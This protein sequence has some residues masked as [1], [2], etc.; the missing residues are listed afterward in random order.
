M[1]WQNTDRVAAASAL[2]RSTWLQLCEH[3]PTVK[4]VVI[5]GTSHTSRVTALASSA[6]RLSVMA[7]A[8]VT[9]EQATSLFQ[10]T[11]PPRV[12]INPGFFRSEFCLVIGRAAVGNFRNP[13][14]VAFLLCW[15]GRSSGGRNWILLY[16]T[17]NKSKSERHST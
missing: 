10:P 14:G 13:A 3:L 11:T 16:C 7:L 1:D 8:S 15:V 2:K 12:S 6:T 4:V 17:E 5:T 9:W